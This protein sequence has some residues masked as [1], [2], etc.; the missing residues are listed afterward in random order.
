MK[1]SYN[2]GT[3]I[4]CSSLEKDLVLCEKAGFDYIEIHAALLLDYVRLHPVKELKD[5]FAKSRLKPHAINAL[6]TYPELFDPKNT[7]KALENDR[8][9]LAYFLSCCQIAKEIGDHYF[10]IV[11]PML[12]DSGSLY[13]P[14]GINTVDYPYSREQVTDFSVR[15]LRTLSPVAAQYEVNLCWE[16]V[17]GRGCSVRTLEHAWEIVKETGCSNVGL[18]VDSVNLHLNGKLND[19]SAIRKVPVDKIFIAH[20]NNCDDR[21]VDELGPAD[22]RFVDSGEIDLNNY[23]S[24]LKAAGFKGPVS[25]ETLRPEYYTWPAEKVVAEAYRTTKELVDKYR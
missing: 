18:A 14:H 13:V 22:R 10:I 25:I 20:I 1:L 11:N 4:G 8:A 2:E 5:F 3:G 16:P 6:F 12:S 17:C 7:G 24:N 15:I 23:L 19:F 9:M 21:P